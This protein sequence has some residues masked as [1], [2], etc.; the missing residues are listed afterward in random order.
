MVIVGRCSLLFIVLVIGDWKS[1]SRRGEF[2]LMSDKQTSKCSFALGRYFVHL[3]GLWLV[4][5][6][7]RMI[8]QFSTVV[9][10]NG[11]YWLL[12]AVATGDLVIG[13]DRQGWALLLSV[14]RTLVRW[15]PRIITLWKALV[16]LLPP[17]S[18]FESFINATFLYGEERFLGNDK[19]IN[20]C[21]DAVWIHFGSFHRS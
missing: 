7:L 11:N 10:N 8:E 14:S 16:S 21:E 2:V 9:D 15:I 17:L 18:Q 3:L 19:Q 12:A 20:A 13:K 5:W 6:K 4:W 1:P